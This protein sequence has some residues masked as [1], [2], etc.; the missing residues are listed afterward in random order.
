MALSKAGLFLF[1]SLYILSIWIVI[2]FNGVA[3]SSSIQRSVIKRP[4]KIMQTWFKGTPYELQA[5]RIYGRHPG[6]TIMIVGGIQGNEPGGFLSADLYVDLNLEKGDLIVIPRANL[7][8]ILLFQRAPDGDM[9]RQF[10]RNDLSSDL[11]SLDGVVNVIKGLMKEADVFLNLHDGRGFHRDTYINSLKN[12]NRFGQTIVIDTD[13]FHCKDKTLYLRDIAQFVV[14][15]VNMRL[16]ETEHF[17]SVFNTNTKNGRSYLAS[18]MRKTATWYA[19]TNLCI[20][21]FGIETSKNLPSLRLKIKYHNDAINAFLAY[22]GIVP[23]YPPLFMSP[24]RLLYMVIDVNGEEEFVLP[25]RKIIIPKGSIFKVKRVET[26]YKRIITCDILGYGSINDIGRPIKITKNTTII[27]RK[28]H[29][30]I[31]RIPLIVKAK[32]PKGQGSK[33]VLVLKKNGVRM[34]L[35]EGNSLT[36]QNGDIIYLEGIIPLNCSFK[37]AYL[38]QDIKVNFKGFEP[39]NTINRGDDRGFNITIGPSLQKRYSVN[40]DGL[41]WPVEARDKRRLVAKFYIGS[42]CP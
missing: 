8:S 10:H 18:E 5:Y 15:E 39:P 16:E 30:I 35:S 11:P 40:G 32:R 4:S 34:L 1:L 33:K 9:N 36:A 17:F 29:E 38:S 12:P 3:Y 6:A 19:I 2:L 22:F 14:D 21:A 41:C 26:N 7:K 13:V 24:P 27:V 42:M 23:E 20:P 37:E 25:K 28:D 31:E